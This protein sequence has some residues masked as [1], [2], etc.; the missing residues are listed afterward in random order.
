VTLGVNPS[1]CFDLEIWYILHRH[2]SNTDEKKCLP[3]DTLLGTAVAEFL[4]DEGWSIWYHEGKE[5]KVTD[6]LQDNGYA[7]DGKITFKRQFEVSFSRNGH[8][9]K[10]ARFACD[11]LVKDVEAFIL[12]EHQDIRGNIQLIFQPDPES[13]L[14]RSAKFYECV[15]Y[16]EVVGVKEI[17]VVFL[18]N[19]CRLEYGRFKPDILV[20]DVKFTVAC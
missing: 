17:P 5:W 2:G 7:K 20:R 4:G 9:W 3:L 8:L 13:P 12:K 19:G 10:R 1:K 11:I 18:A 16:G 14:V 15:T 6:R